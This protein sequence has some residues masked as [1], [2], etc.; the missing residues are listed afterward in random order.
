MDHSGFRVV[1]RRR[2][3]SSS[4]GAAAGMASWLALGKPPARAQQRELTFLSWNHFVPASD[5]EPMADRDETDRLRD[6]FGNPFHPV[7]FPAQWRTVTVLALATQMYESREFG[8][9]PILA[10][11]LVT[12]SLARDSVRP[13][14]CA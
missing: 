13:G 10:Y 7:A 1:D 2:F 11:T 5:D 4:A 9:M 14:T 8:A 12:I 3:L 6:I